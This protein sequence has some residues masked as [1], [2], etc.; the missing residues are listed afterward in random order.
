VVV[1]VGRVV[2]CWDEDVVVVRVELV[3]GS[4]VVEMGFCFTVR[5][6]TLTSAVLFESSVR[7]RKYEGAKGCGREFGTDNCLIFV[8]S[9]SI[10]FSCKYYRS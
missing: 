9:M 8:I 2:L 5:P 1:V 4:V 7:T 3:V 10:K 6:E